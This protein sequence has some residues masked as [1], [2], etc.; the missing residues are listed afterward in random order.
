MAKHK[1]NVRVFGETVTVVGE[2]DPSYIHNLAQDIENRFHELSKQFPSLSKT[3]IAI[4]VTIN[5]ADELQQLKDQ[6]PSTGN[7]E[8]RTKRILSLLEE[9]LT[10]ENF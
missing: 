8:E 3:K 1:V 9:G 4:L 6:P 7:I 10:G 5:M 2:A